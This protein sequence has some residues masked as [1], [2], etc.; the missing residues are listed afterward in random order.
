MNKQ[1]KCDSYNFFESFY[2]EDV[3]NFIKSGTLRKYLNFIFIEN[4]EFRLFPSVF[5][6]LF[7]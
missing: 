2:S 4:I 3:K 6:K 1:K 5:S 7:F